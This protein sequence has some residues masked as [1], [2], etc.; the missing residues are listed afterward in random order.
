MGRGREKSKT[1]KGESKWI[2]IEDRR[3]EWKKA[4]SK[5]LNYRKEKGKS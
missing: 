2:R 1:Q 3:E 4:T 5:Q